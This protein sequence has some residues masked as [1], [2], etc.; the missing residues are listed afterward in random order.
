M[1]NR[2]LV[3]HEEGGRML[4]KKRHS[5]KKVKLKIVIKKRKNAKLIQ[6][7]HV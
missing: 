5:K 2:I 6:V 7:L 1:N 4:N 3:R